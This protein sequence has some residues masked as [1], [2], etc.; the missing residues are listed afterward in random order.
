MKAIKGMTAADILVFDRPYRYTHPSDVNTKR[1]D[2]EMNRGTEKCLDVA[3]RATNPKTG[4]R[5]FASKL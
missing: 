4:R 1:I 5:S 3:V 2:D